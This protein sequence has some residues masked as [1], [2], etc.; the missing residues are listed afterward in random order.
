MSTY[1]FTVK[2]GKSKR[3]STAGKY[4]DRDIIVSGEGASN[5]DTCT[6]VLDVSTFQAY[7]GTVSVFYTQ[8]SG[9]AVGSTPMTYSTSGSL[10]TITLSNVVCGSAVCVFTSVT[11][12]HDA[13]AGETTGYGMT[14][15]ITPTVGAGGT[16]RITFVADD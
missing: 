6:I 8:M 9:G 14:H 2:S 7:S 16:E 5:I 13:T 12:Y 1:N 11:S 4:C 10:Y 15:F 3:L